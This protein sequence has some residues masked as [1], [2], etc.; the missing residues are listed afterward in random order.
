VATSLNNL[1]DLLSD[2]GRMAEAEGALRESLD[3]R[4]SLAGPEPAA[5]L[6][7]VATS[8]NNLGALLYAP[9]R[10]AE[11]EGACHFEHM[12]VV[13]AASG[14]GDAFG[15][16]RRE[17]ATGPRRILAVFTLPGPE[18]SR[19]IF[20]VSRSCRQTALRYLSTLCKRGF[21]YK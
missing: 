2:T 5:F 15:P 6:P 11:A 4:R 16:P 13:L 21:L 3:I 14:A 9:G 19:C 18:Y 12:V 20:D 7:D 17:N 1:G 8:L 10:V